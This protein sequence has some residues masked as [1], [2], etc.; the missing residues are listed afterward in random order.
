[1]STKTLH[2]LLDGAVVGR[3]HQDKYGKLQVETVPQKGAPPISL[4]FPKGE[5]TVGQKLVRPY[6]AGLLPD[7][8]EVRRAMAR[9][10]GVS[11]ESQFAL[12]SKIGEDCPGAIQ[13]LSQP[14]VDNSRDGLS[15][16]SEQEISERLKNFRL[17]QRDWGA[18]AEHWSLAG[19]QAK[20]ALRYENGE[21]FQAL[22]NEA[23]SHIIK[24]GIHRM[25]SQ[26]LLEHV[27]MRTLHHLG[28][29]VARTEFVSFAGEGAI[30]VERFDRMRD[31]AGVLR[32]VHQEDMCQATATLPKNKYEVAAVDVVTAL[33]KF[34]ASE[35]EILKFV[36][37]VLANWVIAAPDAHAKNFSVFLT[38]E[39]VPYLAPL[40]DVATGLGDEKDWDALAMGIGGEKKMLRITGAHVRKFARSLGVPEDA[41]LAGAGML[42]RYA[43]DAFALA[44]READADGEGRKHLNRVNDLLAERSKHIQALLSSGR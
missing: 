13:F 27:S 42:A 25:K 4:S 41:A 20:I 40:Y 3:L 19:A 14:E 37:A 44:A 9:R 7:S 16:I 12:L 36:Q 1:M 5:T 10:L 6:L 23:T 21:W 8:E 11:P 35:E 34:G 32:R 31:D 22:G 33:R 39:G 43:P 15:P 2:M 18:E 30:V 24:P 29:S 28:L 38:P 17:G 26:A